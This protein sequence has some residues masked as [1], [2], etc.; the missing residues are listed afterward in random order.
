MRRVA[1]ILFFAFRLWALDPKVSLSQYARKTWQVEDGLPQNYVTWIGQSADGY[2]LVGTSGGA[3]RFDG[4]KFTP[5]VLDAA[6]GLTREWITVVQAGKDAGTIWVATRDSGF[7]QLGKKHWP[8]RLDSLI[9]DK[10]GVPVGL[11]PGLFRA[12]GNDLTK[13]REGLSPSDPSWSGLLE[14]SA[15]LLVASRQGL[16]LLADPKPPSMLLP[17]SVLALARST[18]RDG[19][20]LGLSHGV[21]FYRMSQKPEMF[22]R[23]SRTCR[24]A[25]RGPGR[26]AV[27]G[28]LGIWFVARSE[29]A[30]REIHDGG[31]ARRQL[32][33]RPVRGS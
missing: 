23:H 32:R 31:G 7:Y 10:G 33:P 17:Y 22:V 11:G 14:V 24:V 12:G 9:V 16:Y 1:Y 27:G 28:D 6:T 13:V 30:R 8:V 29:R 5:L 26:R 19:V 15:G 18:R 21:G 25:A 3:A 4:L 20:W 2:L